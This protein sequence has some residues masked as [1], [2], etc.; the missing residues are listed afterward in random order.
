VTLP[1]SGSTLEVARDLADTHLAGAK[2]ELAWN[3][4]SA[5]KSLAG[6]IRE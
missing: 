5:R 6:V 4:S 2:D 3:D 1:V